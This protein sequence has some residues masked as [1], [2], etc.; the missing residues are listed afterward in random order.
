MSFEINTDILLIDDHPLLRKGLSQLI[1]EEEG[2]QVVGEAG[3]GQ[4]GLELARKLDPDL[5]LLDLNMKGMDGLATL[6]AMRAEGVSSRIVVLTVSEHRDDV[7]AMF[8]SGADGYL[9]KDMDP[10]ELLERV[11]EAATGKLVVD[12]RLA[13]TLA[14]VLRPEPEQENKLDLLTPKETEVLYFIAEGDAN[15]VIARKMDISEGTVKVH[16]KRVLRKLGFRSRVEAAVW[17]VNRKGK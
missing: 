5:I 3:D 4:A 15:K 12:D 13:N 14:S 7:A 8:R 1:N 11:A 10:E 6:K 9:L 16:V 2:L 17:W